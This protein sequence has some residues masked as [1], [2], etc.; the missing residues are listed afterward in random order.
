LPRK[1]LVLALV[2]SLLTNVLLL[3][4]FPSLVPSYVGQKNVVQLNSPQV[5][6]RNSVKSYS[7]IQEAINTSEVHICDEFRTVSEKGRCS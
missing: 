4:P 3:F 2:F 5:F 1:A 7:T 6:N